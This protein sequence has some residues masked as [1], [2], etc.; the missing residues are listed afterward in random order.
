MIS[1]FKRRPFL[2]FILPAFVFYTVFA[3]YPIVGVLPYAFTK[4][5]GIGRPEFVGLRNFA[6]IFGTP[7]L[8]TQL[9]NSLKN[10][11]LLLALTYVV[12]TPIILVVAYLLFKRIPGSSLYK[13]VLFMPQF[14]NVV[15]VTFIVTL[16]FS[17]TIGLYEA[18]MNA[19]GLGRWAVPGIWKNTSMGMP[20]VLLVGVWKGMGYELLLFIAGFSTV[21]AELEESA[22]LDGAGE[23]RRF[24]HIYF[25]L[26]SPTFTNVIVLMYIW[27]LTTF[28]V[29]YLMG[30]MNGG[31][32]GC[33]DTIQ[34]FFYRTVFGRSSYS[35]NFMGMGSALSV[36]I[37]SVLVGGSL[38]LQ[39]LLRRRE[40]YNN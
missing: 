18:V 28:D 20:L 40:F 10:T 14:V 2:L 13:A 26:V 15:A 29:P 12:Y 31:A 32:G 38:L 4:W 8:V 27:T 5:S 1:F 35:S 23:V 39:S 19:L 36:I 9:A 37:L 30:G 17:P 16:F 6:V 24:I 3:I 25:P 11:G 21:P 7:D 33:M 22:K 34:L